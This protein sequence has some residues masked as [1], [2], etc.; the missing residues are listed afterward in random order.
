MPNNSHLKQLK[1]FTK[2]I[3]FE[4]WGQILMWIEFVVFEWKSF[5]AQAPIWTSPIS[6]LVTLCKG[7]HPVPYLL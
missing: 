5:Y 4:K 6:A 7:W 1:V 2:E 3:R